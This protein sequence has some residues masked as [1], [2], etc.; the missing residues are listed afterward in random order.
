MTTPVNALTIV[1]A[2][3]NDSVYS[4]QFANV[5]EADVAA[6]LAILMDGSSYGLAEGTVKAFFE[7]G[8]GSAALI[9]ATTLAKTLYEAYRK[10]AGA[11]PTLD[12]VPLVMYLD[13]YQD[14][15]GLGEYCSQVAGFTITWLQKPVD[16]LGLKDGLRKVVK[17]STF[18][19]AVDAVNANSVRWTLGPVPGLLSYDQ[20]IS[21]VQMIF[22]DS[23]YELNVLDRR[24]LAYAEAQQA[25]S[26][27]TA[28]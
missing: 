18:I 23:G 11:T 3:K 28:Q 10:T 2:A 15:D 27:Q 20:A 25:T 1:Q 12:V 14:R 24:G 13:T 22:A 5:N 17:D 8:E 7:G 4:A 6:A 26:E 21:T 9:N 19:T 16:S